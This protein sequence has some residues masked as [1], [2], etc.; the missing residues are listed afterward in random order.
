MMLI[1]DFVPLLSSTII[2]EKL[3]GFINRYAEYT[4]DKWAFE[5]VE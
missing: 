5:K 3:D 4:H 1:I 2:P